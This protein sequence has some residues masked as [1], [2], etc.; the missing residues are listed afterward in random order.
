MTQLNA[1]LLTLAVEGA[2]GAVL[3]RWW[4][5]LRGASFVRAWM[6][7]LAASLLTHPLAW[8]AN[9]SWLRGLSFVVRAP[10]IELAVVFVEGALFH[11]AWRSVVDE[12]ASR[13]P[14]SLGRCL[15]FSLGTNGASFG[16][17]LFLLL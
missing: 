14:L 5:G 2:V 10:I 6:V 13:G 1:L 8:Q 11:R 7:V 12:Q 16:Y 3:L 15:L 9:R 17:G 4:L